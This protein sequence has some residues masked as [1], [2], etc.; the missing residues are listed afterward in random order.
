MGEKEPENQEGGRRK[1]M[2]SVIS[3]ASPSH[4][5]SLPTPP[6]PP[7][8]GTT[9]HPSLF[10]SLPPLLSEAQGLARLEKPCFFF[11]SKKM[12]VRGCKGQE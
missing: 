6:L 10:F 4:N 11:L 9:F 7:P 2:Y 3:S 5:F 1:Y 8:F 12:G